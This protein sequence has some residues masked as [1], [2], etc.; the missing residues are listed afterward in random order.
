MEYFANFGNGLFW[1]LVLLTPLV[2]VHE[3]GH[4][5][6]ARW[7]GVRV[8]VFSIG[9]G[10]E[11][12]GW[13]DRRNT[14]WKFAAIPLGGYIKM[15]GEHSLRPGDD[16][17]TRELTDAEKAVSIEHKSLPQRAAVVAAG[18]GA[19]YLFAVLILTGMFAIVGQS[20]TP[21]QIG[22]V[23]DGT[24]AAA[25]GLQD[26]DLVVS[27][28]GDS[29]NTFAELIRIVR[30][31]PDEVL[32]IVVR[33]NDEDVT[34]QAMTAGID[35]EA[36][37]GLTVREGRLGI[38]S[39]MP[40][41]VGSV[42]PES[43]AAE[44]GLLPGD[45]FISVDGTR[46][47]NFQDLQGLVSVAA[48]QVLTVTILRGEDELV[49]N[50]VPAPHER[51]TEDGGTEII[52][53]MGVQSAV[54]G[55]LVR[56]GPFAALW[57]GTALTI[58]MNWRILQSIGQL[59]AGQRDTKEL[60]GPILIAQAAQDVSDRGLVQFL[61]FMAIFSINLGLI[62]LFPVPVLDGGHLLFYA[63]EAILGRPLNE[64]VQEYSLRIGLALLVSLMI[65][66]VFNDLL[67]RVL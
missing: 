12:F 24:P 9:F 63:I 47:N 14:R 21:P 13:T 39:F 1:F 40:A 22:E 34:L 36:S 49:V 2:F 44:A 23:A 5:L 16:G 59:F 46:I 57:E 58:D 17:E 33:R 42:V 38:V 35:V 67:Y 27:V 4:F 15:F 52:G 50:V 8:E 3:M 28:D 41:T 6:V 61:S 31:S 65:F 11:I 53:L 66:V 25:A 48:D 54:G 10:P 60:G 43:P 56:L 18:P 30:L 45:R 51:A 7:C 32:E 55:K 20:M 37:G 62:N 64:K 26:G 29:I 19:N